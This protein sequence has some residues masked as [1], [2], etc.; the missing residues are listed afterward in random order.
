[1]INTGRCLERIGY[2]GPAEPGIETLRALQLAFLYAI[3]FE[4]LDIHLGTRITLSSDAIFEKIVQRGRGGVC[5]ELNILFSDL[6]KTLG[7]RVHLLSAR[8]V[9][10]GSTGPEFDHMVLRISL[11]HDYLVDVGNGH[12]CREPLRIDGSATAAAE[13]YVYRAGVSDGTFALYRSL[14]GKAWVPRLLFSTTPRLQAD[15]EPMNVYHQTAAE[16]DFKRRRLITIATKGGRVSLIDRHLV[17][18]DGSR[19]RS[20]ELESEDEYR[21][22]LKQYFSIEFPKWKE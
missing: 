13:G 1:M 9:R 11:D 15:F 8:I 21:A 6:L 3:P 2:D 17:L 22:C 5:F 12:F 4:N 20:R 18:F 10:S 19:K 14:P 16:S 7:F